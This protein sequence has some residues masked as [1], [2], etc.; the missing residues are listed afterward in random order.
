MDKIWEAMQLS[1]GHKAIYIVTPLLPRILHGA[2]RAGEP[3]VCMNTHMHALRANKNYNLLVL[4]Y[5]Q[6]L[7]MRS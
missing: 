7:Y 2:G 3:R 5:P 4:Y 6:L 1:A